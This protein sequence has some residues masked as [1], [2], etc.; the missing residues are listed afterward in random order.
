MKTLIQKGWKATLCVLVVAVFAACSSDSSDEVQ[1]PHGTDLVFTLSANDKTVTF[2]MKLVK[3][4]TFQMG[5]DAEGDDVSPVHEV[6][7]SDYY[8]G[9]TEVTQG[10]W[11]TVTG[12]TPTDNGSKQWESKLG[13]GDTYPA[14]Y[15]S[16]D[17]AKDFLT[18]LNAALANKLPEGKQFR[19]PTEA[20]WEYAAKGGSQSQH[21][22]YAGSNDIEEVAW[23]DAICYKVSESDPNH[24]THAVKTKAANELGLYDM[25]GNVYEWCSDWYG[26]Y[27]ESVQ[28]NPTGPATGS[29]RVYRGGGWSMDEWYARSVH[30]NNSTSNSRSQNLGLRLAL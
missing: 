6:T 9:E 19:L 4:G 17:D 10:L 22:V 7:L 25:S 29:F 23:Y 26:A 2:N 11:E 30:R 1:E 24:G 20:E 28:T 18:K 8:I 13:R 12:K 3:G 15:V 5:K 27:P 21:F 14:Y 16:W